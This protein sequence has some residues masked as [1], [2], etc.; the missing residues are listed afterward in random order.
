MSRGPVAAR[1]AELIATE[2]PIPVSTFV[3]HSLYGPGGFYMDGGRAGRRGDFLTA[4]EVGPLFGAVLARAIDGWWADLGRPEVYTVLE[5]GA[6]PG[7]L[8]R[9]VLAAEPEVLATG[10]LRWVMVERSEAQREWH[11]VH[12]AVRSAG[13]GDVSAVDA[14]LVLANELLDNLAFDIVERTVDG[15][16]EIRI[17]DV[18]GAF[19]EI[20]QPASVP[21]E[22]PA[23]DIAVGVRLPWQRTAREWLAEA[24]AL[25]ARGRVVVFDYGATTRELAE[26]NGGWLRTHAGHEGG[27][28]W[29]RE[30]GTCDITSDVDFDQLQADHRADVHEE[31]A[32]W[33][34]RHGIDQLVEEGRAIWERSAG[35][36]DLAALTAR[37][38]IRE[39]DALTDADGM[40]A[41]HVLEWRIDK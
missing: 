3:D 16:A 36:G 18:D 25:V 20:W 24:R 34:A 5:W 26:R 23:D 17:G 2:G 39:A 19:V 15:W 32:V 30:P 37:S 27:A 8:A 35:V 1:L 6:G 22:L 10:A 12:D 4:P 38:R 31:Q 14:G 28:D 33:L 7:T 41:F 40:G 13:P 9:A 11:P 21:V 29:L